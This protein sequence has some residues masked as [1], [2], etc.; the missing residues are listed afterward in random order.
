[1]LPLCRYWPRCATNI[2][3][4]LIAKGTSDFE[5]I[6]FSGTGKPAEISQR[7]TWRAAMPA[8]NRGG[9]GGVFLAVK[10]DPQAV[11]NVADDLELRDLA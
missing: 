9:G 11:A 8:F 2:K 4:S 7:A 5:D 6:L 10:G 3:R 1:M